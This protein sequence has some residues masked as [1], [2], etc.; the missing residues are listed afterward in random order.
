VTL[1][2]ARH[3]P[4]PRHRPQASGPGRPPAAARVVIT[5]MGASSAFGRGTGPLRD[6]TLAGEPAFS[7][8]T[9]FRA[10]GCRV[11][12][13]ALLPGRPVLA[14]ELAA[15]LDEACEQASLGPALRGRCPLLVAL[16]SDPEAAR[17]PAAPKVTGPAAE[18]LAAG[19]GMPA[20]PRTYVA[21]CV[22][23]SSAVADAA[24]MISTGEADRVAV[25]AGFLVDA[26]SQA[27][28]DAGRALATDGQVRPF[29][30]GRKGMLLGDGAAAVICE[31]AD[32]AAARGAT[33]L[34]VLAGWG[35]AGDAYHVCQPRPDGSGCARAIGSALRRAGASPGDICYVNANGTGTT[36]S[37]AAESAALH[38][39]LGGA[40]ERI[41]VSST[42]SLHGHTLEA[43]GLVELVATVLALRAGLLPVNAGF[44]GPDRECALDLV[45]PV[46]RPSG[47]GYALSL[48]SAFGGANTALVVGA[49]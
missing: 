47:P 9:R 37:D 46:P 34:A 38:L 25:A 1:S 6:G 33:A 31:S 10:G 3:M 7:Q 44:L 26:D 11:R 18:Q 32:A 13:A 48:N 40:A 24:T 8:V 42:K 30:T 4:D 45:Q 21:A 35:R 27:L 49:A 36:F 19:C 14:D 2:L 15:V 12:V 20:P 5:G 41:P 23:A 28:F 22:A 17:Q 39:A 29:S 43:S 16:H